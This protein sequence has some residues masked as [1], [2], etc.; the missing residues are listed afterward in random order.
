LRLEGES[1]PVRADVLKLE[2]VFNNLLGNAVKFSP[3]GSL[4]E[5]DLYDGGLGEYKRIEIRDQGPGVPADDL[6]RIFDRFYQVEKKGFVPKRAFGAGLGLSIVRNIIGLHGGQVFAAN[7]PEG[8]CIFTVELPDL[9]AVHS[10]RDIAALIVDAQ[11]NIFRYLEVPLRT[12]GIPYFIVKNLS[13]ARRVYDHERPEVIF[14]SEVSITGELEDFLSKLQ[15]ERNPRP[16]RVLIGTGEEVGSESYD[17]VITLPLL[18]M[19]IYSLLQEE[20]T[21]NFGVQGR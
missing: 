3:D 12:L 20:L 8:G 4:I 6:D 1:Q 9:R 2:Q 14:A 7:R 11:E 18:D 10:S 16:L 13:E 21:H 5:V 15:F 17:Q 19:E